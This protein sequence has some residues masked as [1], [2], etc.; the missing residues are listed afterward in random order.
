MDSHLLSFLAAKTDPQNAGLWL[1][2]W[3]HSRDTA[4]VMRRLAIHWLSN[5]ARAALGLEEALLS[6]LAYFLGAVHDIGKATVL[7][8]SNITQRL[9]EV[10]ERLARQCVFPERFVFPRATPHAKASEAIL[11]QLGCPKGVASIAGAHHGKPQENGQNEY[12]EEN[13]E[14]YHNNYYGKGEKDLWFSLWKQMLEQHLRDA[15]FASVEELPVLTIPQ[16]LLLT[17]LL[18]M[19]DWIASNTSFFPL[20]S[21]E[22]LGS[23][24]LYPKRIADGWERI[25]LPEPWQ[26]LS[27]LPMDPGSFEDRF[28]FPPNEVQQA[29]LDVAASMEAPGLLILEAQMGVG[30]TEAALAAAETFAAKW[31]AG[32]LFFGL[33]TQATANGIFGR[34]TAWAQTQSE[35]T[36]HSIRLAH[37]MA[38]L[39]EDYRELFPGRSFVE[40]EGPEEGVSVHPW[41]QGNKQ[42]LL[43]DFVIGTV[44][45]LLM[46]ALKQKHLMLRHLGVAGKVVVVDEIHACDSYMST[47]LDRALSWLGCYHVPVLLLSATLPA[48]RRAELVAAYLGAKTVDRKLFSNRGY[49]LLTWTS[50]TTVQQR[51]VALSAGQ[52]QVALQTAREDALPQLL[53]EALAEGGCAGIIVNTVKKAQ[54]IA[55]QLQEKMPEYQVVLFHAQF[56]MPD[57]A[58]KERILLER[59]GKRSTPEQ[60]DRLIVVGTQVLEQSLDIDF[61]FL[62]VELCPMDLLL[63]RI[64][65]EHRHPGHDPYRPP[66]L[67]QARCVV[68]TAEDGFDEGSKAVYGE[69]LLWRTQMLLPSAVHLPEDIPS[70]VQ[71]TYGWEEQDVL[72][73]TEESER[74]LQ[75]YQLKEKSKREN[76]GQ[77]L[78]LPPKKRTVLAGPAVLDGWMRDERAR[79]ES[80]AR[81]AVRDGDP[82]IEVLVMMKCR[83]G[84]VG[85]LPWQE[86]GAAVPTDRPPSQEESRAIARQ[87]LRL[88]GYFSRRWAIDAVIGE[89]EDQNRC[90]LGQWQQAPM[91][92]GE[93]V[94]LLDEEFSTHLAGTRIVYDRERGL[95]YGKEEA[96]ERD[97][98]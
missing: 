88:P 41:F 1:P 3:I 11:L 65:R 53:E 18:I 58:E 37:G 82:S 78:I 80:Q 85:F 57:R 17:G 76:A 86:G 61:D 56:L 63:Q 50:G 25:H 52:R 89:L 40:K 68:L 96:C 97:G 77:F 45:Q 39:N 28:G 69:W 8:Q 20:L 95:T 60:R 75:L 22:D 49:P 21:A 7:F 42:A 38:E 14:S 81:A 64:G 59:L 4:E 70:L 12:I 44:D 31:G 62:V 36:A 24:S 10:R 66:R 54:A 33:P 92:E 55:N 73:E 26:P 91:L 27:Y 35:D 23:A 47:Y 84:S 19:A 6:K 72:S 94:L 9:P 29:V 43:A 30:K 13:I 71:D 87:R 16:E 5:G 46:A 15:G 34:L 32:G 98:I 2:L 93:L 90:F 51:V 48:Q 79:S 83:D 74:A 67:R